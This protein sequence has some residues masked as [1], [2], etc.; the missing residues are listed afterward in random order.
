MGIL[1]S[2][3]KTGIVVKVLD[4]VR[5]EAAKPQNQ[6]KARQ[7]LDRASR[8]ASRSRRDGPSSTDR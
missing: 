1:R 4:V 8:R 5:R 7:L 6:E 2:A 3:L